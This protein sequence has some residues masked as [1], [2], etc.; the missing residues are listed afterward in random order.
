[1]PF[2]LGWLALFA[3]P[4]AAVAHHW[5]AYFYTTCAAGG[6]VLVAAATA[7]LARWGVVALLMGLLWWHAASS[8]VPAFALAENPWTWTSHL[9]PYYFER[10]AALSARLRAALRRVAPAPAQGTRFFFATLPPWAGFQMGN[11]PVIRDLYRDRSLESY[12]YTQF[13][14]STAAEHP[15]V[16]LFWNGVDFER[17]Y[18]H[19]ADPFFQVGADLLLLDRPAGAIHAFRRGLGRGENAV[20][21]T[22][23]L[24]W[25][26]LWAGER[27]PAE[28]AWRAFGARDDSTMFVAWLRAARTV[29]DD[30]DTLA[31]RRDLFEAVRAGI[32]RP[33]PHA[34]LGELLGPRSP[35]FALLETKVAARL[36]PRD[37]LA[38]RDLVDGLAR[39]RLDEVARRELEALQAIEPRWRQDSVTVGLARTLADRAPASA[40]VASFEGPRG[41]GPGAGPGP[42]QR[43]GGRR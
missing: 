15:C 40:T 2:A 13:S 18:A 6:A 3:L 33:E 17:L 4:V 10:G 8:A 28:Q 42:A 34:A 39:A 9:T 12:F 29:L 43:T 21:L 31:A 22:Y 19:G 32:G 5:S 16:F 14:E 41:R 20:D 27:A 11:G 35:K 23:W 7:R 30:G 1:V 26:F 24:G 37:W 25:A 38:R 36:D